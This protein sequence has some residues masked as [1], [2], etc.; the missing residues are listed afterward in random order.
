MRIDVNCDMGESFGA[1]TLGSDSLLMPLV[2]SAN[3]ACGFHA[4]DPL[5]MDRTVMLARDHNVAVGAHPGYRDLAGFGRRA[6][7]ARPEEIQADVLY[8]IG[9]LAAFARAHGAALAHVKP[10]GALYNLAAARPEIARAIARATAAYDPNLYLYCLAGSALV[11]AAQQHGLH[12]VREG[13]PDRAYNRDGTLR[14]RREPG[15]VITDPRRVA[16][17]ALQMVRTQ[18]VTTPEG[19]TLALVVDTLCIHGDN[20]SAVE[21]AR[22]LREVLERNGVTLSAPGAAPV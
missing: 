20:P 21:N 3:V 19:E 11:D 1:Y 22:A 8:Q 10:H 18:S 5:I 16:E 14:S 17:Q 6:I 15:A 13:F 9:A 7:D 12:V 4:G 2:S